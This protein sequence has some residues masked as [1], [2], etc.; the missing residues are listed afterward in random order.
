MLILLLCGCTNE[1]R[2]KV[3]NYISDNFNFKKYT[4]YQCLI[5]IVAKKWNIYIDNFYYP[6]LNQ[7]NNYDLEKRTNKQVL[8][9]E[10][11]IILQ[12]DKT[13][14]LN[15][16]C[17]KILE[18]NIKKVIITNFS[19]SYE[20]SLLKNTFPKSIIIPIQIKELNEYEFFSKDYFII[21]NDKNIN[22]NI[23][24]FMNYIDN[25]LKNIYV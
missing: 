24:L 18:E 8:I 11:K 22:D 21:K 17:E 13:I 5:E 19:Y 23:E 25:E 10:C 2:N 12:E 15:S 16:I 3:A 20:L 4:Y 14:F 9:D 6:K 1:I 7:V